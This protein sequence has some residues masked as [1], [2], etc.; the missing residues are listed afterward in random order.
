MKHLG[1]ALSGGGFRATLYHLG[2]VRFLHDAGLLQQ[3][4][5]MTSVSGGSILAAHLALNWNEYC[6]TNEEFDAAAAQIIK[7][8]QLDVRNRIVRRYPLYAMG[9]ALLRLVGRKSIRRLTRAGLLEAYYEKHLYGDKCLFQLPEQPELHILATNL[10]EG[11]LCSFNREG[12]SMQSRADEPV[13]Q[14]PAGLATIP[15]AVAASSVFPGFFPPFVLRA[16]DVGESNGE[17]DLQ[18]FTDGG[19]F[20]NLG[21]RFF[22][23]FKPVNS[24]ERGFDRVLVSDAG[25]KF[26]VID[27]A[28]TGGLIKTALRA[29]DILM[30]RVWSLEVEH[31]QDKEDFTFVSISEVVG[32]HDDPHGPHIE[33]QRQAARIRTDMDAFSDLE[34]RSLVEHGYC[35]ARH[36]CLQEPDIYGTDLPDG[37]PWDP[38]RTPS[39]DSTP[40]LSESD[41]YAEI[42]NSARRLKHSAQRRI[43]STLLSYKDWPTYVW[44]PLVV[45]LFTWM[46]WSYYHASER[47]NRNQLIVEAISDSSPMYRTILQ[48]LDRGPI[49]S[50][51]GMHFEQSDQPAASTDDTPNFQIIRDTRI[52]D[53][54]GWTATND[55]DERVYTHRNLRVRRLSADE[56][57]SALLQLRLYTRTTELDLRCDEERLDPKL[58]RYQR[59]DE[60]AWD[61]TLDFQHIP[62]GKDIDIVIEML[63][64]EGSSQD[65]WFAFSVEKET[66]IAKLWVLMPERRS[67]DAFELFSYERGKP[68]TS[69]VEYPSNQLEIPSGDVI[70]FEL[71]SPAADRFYEC[72]WTW[73]E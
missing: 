42:V 30:N 64:P 2:V 11:C 4:T 5:H 17:F 62:V 7:F 3:V 28:A 71:V 14:V 27:E 39:P 73:S 47:A 31:F 1:L 46:P 12:L 59:G 32:P 13:K 66:V 40:A 60:Y 33:L 53:L 70:T 51:A 44:V 9:N 41:A 24:K 67:Y 35:G 10:S 54:R 8:A 52:V 43:F 21:V 29:S 69:E 58:V 49:T 36:A 38:I 55:E 23:I 57:N 20:D 72:N 6:G 25:G 19:V 15:M 18:A 61:L 26:K 68:E 22:K 37:P 45:L 50:L 65:G 48:Q 63:V 56:G 16:W 34:I